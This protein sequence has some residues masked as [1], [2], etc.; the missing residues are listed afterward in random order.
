MYH[1]RWVEGLLRTTLVPVE[2]G[3]VLPTPI[4][5]AILFKMW[6]ERGGNIKGDCLGLLGL[7]VTHCFQFVYVYYFSRLLD[8]HSYSLVFPVSVVDCKKIADV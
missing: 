1:T 8:Y 7:L 6:S 3:G 5:W 4:S 2:E